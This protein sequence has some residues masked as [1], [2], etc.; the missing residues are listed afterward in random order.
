M[1]KV[2]RIQAMART[3]E[4]FT[5]PEGFDLA[6]Y[7]GHTWGLLRGEAGEPEE[8]VLEFT[9]DAARWV[10]DEEWHPGQRV[11][12]TPRRPVRLIFHVGITAEM[13]RWVLGFGR[14]VRVIKP[15]HLAEWV[16]EEVG[17]V[18]GELSTVLAKTP[19]IISE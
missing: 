10:R 4:H 1:F 19:E 2:D 11:E 8:V 6:G 3:G 17:A 5:L 7:L 16:R 14:Q 18:S 13:R 9:P 12:G 15:A